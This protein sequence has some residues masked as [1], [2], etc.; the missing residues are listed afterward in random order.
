MPSGK[1][2][3]HTSQVLTCA[4][5]WHFLSPLRNVFDPFDLRNFFMA[6]FIAFMDWVRPENFADYGP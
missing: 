1:C 6:F 3:S 2:L 4:I 5:L